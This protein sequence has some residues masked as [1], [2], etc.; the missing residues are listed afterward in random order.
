M[1][2]INILAELDR[3]LDNS[4]PTTSPI[5]RTVVQLARDEIA[6]LRAII[7]AMREVLDKQERALKGKR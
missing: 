4:N 7:E 5:D 3:W 6:A 2:D 1:N